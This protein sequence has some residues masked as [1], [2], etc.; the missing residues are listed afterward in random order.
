MVAMATS[1]YASLAFYD[2]FVEN[3]CILYKKIAVLSKTVKCD[4]KQKKTIECYLFNKLGQML[5]ISCL[6]LYRVCVK[7]YKVMTNIVF[8]F[9]VF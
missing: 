1:C 6:F 2:F 9:I 5:F 7:S 4:Y 8:W 3:V